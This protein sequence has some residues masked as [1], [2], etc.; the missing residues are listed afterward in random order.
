VVVERIAFLRQ[1]LATSE[2]DLLHTYSELR[3]CPAGTDITR[4]QFVRM[5]LKLIYELIRFGAEQTKRSA[6]INSVS[7]ARLAGIIVSIAKSFGGDKSGEIPI[8]ML[9]PF[10]LNEDANTFIMETREIF[11]NLIKQ[12]KLPVSVIASLSKVIST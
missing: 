10:P 11:K 9:L 4:E 2:L 5:P 7:T 1:Y 6:N 12:R 3:A 8:D